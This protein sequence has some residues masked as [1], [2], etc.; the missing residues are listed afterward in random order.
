MPIAIAVISLVV[1]SFLTF[2]VLSVTEENQLN[3]R[4]LASTASLYAANSSADVSWFLVKPQ[5]SLETIFKFQQERNDAS[6]PPTP[7]AALKKDDIELNLGVAMQT[8][9]TVLRIRPDQFIQRFF[10]SS[11]EVFLYDVRED[12]AV[13]EVVMEYCL[14]GKSCPELIIEW[15]AIGKEIQFQ[16]L[17]VLKDLTSETAPLSD[18]FSFPGISVERC[19]IRTSQP[20]PTLSIS[21]GATGFQKKFWLTTRFE[22]LHYLIRFR[23][24]DRTAF[25]FAMYGKKGET[26]VALPNT[27]FEV[28]ETMA[29]QDAYRRV[30]Q[31]KA[32]SGGLQDA[33]EF[34]HFAENVA[35]K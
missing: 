5:K 11:A 7:K 22:A 2:T 35:N 18:C 28:D 23:S 26:M 33:L 29:M 16:Q 30:R 14:L 31:Q 1:S 6:D 17:Q 27:T 3:Q 13:R 24:V 32:V 8:Q 12:K 20:H 9:K 21:D 4:L 15:F 10:Q 19:A 25:D 34:A